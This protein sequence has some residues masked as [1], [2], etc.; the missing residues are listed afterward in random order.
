MKVQEKL[1][2]NK[3]TVAFTFSIFSSSIPSPNQFSDSFIKSKINKPLK[4]SEKTKKRLNQNSL[5]V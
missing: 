3:K 5:K 1:I 4:I 2:K